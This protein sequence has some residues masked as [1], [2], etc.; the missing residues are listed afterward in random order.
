MAHSRM[1][2]ALRSSLSL[3]VRAD[4]LGISTSEAL[5]RQAAA[6][7]EREQRK[8]MDRRRFL[9]AVGAA[10]VG[11]ALASKGYSAAKVGG[12]PRIAIIGGGL[13]GL[14]CADTLAGKGFSAT[15][16]E[17]NTR[18][19]GRV[20]S[21]ATTFPGQVAEIG[22][23][24]IDNPH[25]TML[26]YA[27]ALGLAKED[28]SKAGGGVK[29]FVGGQLYDDRAVIE[30]FRVLT[31]R[32]HD[33][34]FQLNSP[35]FYSYTPAEEALDWLDLKTWLDTRAGDLPLIRSVLDVAYNIEYGVEAHEQ[36]SLAILQFI[37]FNG[38]S[39]F[40]P[41]GCSDE[42]YHLV[43]GNSAIVEGIASYLP[44]PI[45]YGAKL[46]RLGKLASG[47]F[48]MYFNGSSTPILADSVVLTIP[49]STLRSVVLEPSLGLSA[50]KQR[51]IDTYLY[52]RNVKTMIGFN[53]RP[54][55]TQYDC[56]GAIYSDLPHV[57][58]TWESNFSLAGATS[59]LTD[60]SGG[61][62]GHD[63]QLGLP[64]AKPGCG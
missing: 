50:D 54:W 51:V 52:G 5:E 17:S 9:G 43:G 12:A 18:L 35:T 11:T 30:E 42:R 32:V 7:Y 1:F 57:N 60:Y 38:R 27:N 20:H 45:Q 34:L 62:R 29:Y 25:K 28:L 8:G 16:Y 59:I 58:T 49:F 64:A 40:A 4:R 31:K 3:G 26:A 48:A 61:D 36:S 47:E 24:L 53:G 21:D 13:A 10:A 46:T 44:G 22:G 56:N 19:G 6:E 63:L 23:E 33:D 14:V 41:F 55:L 15:I 2:A 37:K 39:K